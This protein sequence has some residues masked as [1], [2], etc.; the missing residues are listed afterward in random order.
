MFFIN[1]SASRTV[2]IINLLAESDMGLTQTEIS[3]TLDLPK[4]STFDLLNTLIEKD[5]IE[6]TERSRTYKLG[7][8]LISIGFAALGKA[9]LLTVAR[10]FLEQLSETCAE[11]VFLA[12]PSV[13]DIV[14]LDRVE[15]QGSITTG[16]RVGTKR[17][18][19][20]TGIGKAIL[21]SFSDVELEQVW[22]NSEIKQYT[23]QTITDLDTMKQE[24]NESRKRGYS[25]DN[26]EGEGEIYCF[27]VPL[28]DY[29]NEV[30]GAISIASLY[31]R[32]NEERRL[33]FVTNLVKTGLAI[34]KRFGYFKS[35]LY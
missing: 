26:C 22:A 30:I 31:S 4:S 27:A 24:M 28:R 17:P 20:C 10:P 5:Y 33:K 34:S 14:Y 32:M 19:Y 15:S 11:T 6:Y 12:V 23:K 25:I 3:T 1:K 29:T 21:A 7:P 18:M 35:S 2:D 8:K 16:A 9:D 13:P